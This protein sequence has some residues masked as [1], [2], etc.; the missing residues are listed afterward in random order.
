MKNTEKKKQ[1]IEKRGHR[2]E[3]C[4]LTEWLNQPIKLEVHHID[5]DN[6]NNQDDNL[7]LLC[8][9]CHAQTDSYRGKNKYSCAK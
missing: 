1:L 6:T 9:N 5:G 2:C 7:Q 3:C 8:P 4:G